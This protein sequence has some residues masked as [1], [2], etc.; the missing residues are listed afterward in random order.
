MASAVEIPSIGVM[1]PKTQ[2]FEVSDPG[3]VV[4]IE[5]RY[6]DITWSL[7]EIDYYIKQSQSQ[8]QELRDRL[9]Y[10]IRLREKVKEVVDGVKLKTGSE[11]ES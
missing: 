7:N 11:K 5:T 4:V 10:F 8:I 9:D 6:K 1:S 2:D 3:L